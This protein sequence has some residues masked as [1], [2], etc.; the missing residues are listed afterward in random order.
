MEENIDFYYDDAGLMVLTRHFL[1]KRGKCC[2]GGCRNCPY[3]FN[4]KDDFV[5]EKKDD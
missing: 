5:E 2:K 4:E 1:L 3:G